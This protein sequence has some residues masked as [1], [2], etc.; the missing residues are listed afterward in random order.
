[1]LACPNVL[2]C[3]NALLHCPNALAC[4]VCALHDSK[5]GGGGI[6]L[7]GIM[8]GGDMPLAGGIPPLLCRAGGMLL[9]C[10]VVEAYHYH[11]VAGG[12]LLMMVAYCRMEAY[13]YQVVA[14][15]CSDNL[16]AVA[17]A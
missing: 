17:S 9:P 12:I 4:A 6:L 3:L 2:T 5:P 10:G 16:V 1:V 13:R 11:V 7:G 15:H 14:Y 8:P